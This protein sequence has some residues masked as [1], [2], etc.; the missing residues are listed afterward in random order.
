MTK[1]LIYLPLEKYKSR[2]TEYVS[3]ANGTFAACVQEYG[4]V[5]LDIIAPDDKVREITSGVVLDT[6]Q[7]VKWGFSQTEE[8]IRRIHSGEITSNSVIYIE[9]FWHPGMEM[10]PYAC[11]LQGIKPKVYALLHAQSVDPYDFTHPMASWMRGF[12]QGWANWLTGIFVSTK[13]LKSLVTS[14]APPYG[15]ITKIADK[16]HVVGLPYHRATVQNMFPPVTI[17]SSKPRVVFTSRFDAEKQPGKFLQLASVYRARH[18]EVEFM[19][20]SGRSLPGN[21]A[22]QAFDAGVVVSHNVS[23][24]CYFDLLST[25]NVMFN[26]ALQDFISWALIDALAYG[27]TPLLPDYLTFPDVVGNNPDLLYKNGDMHDALK[28]LDAL[29]NAPEKIDYWELY[30]KK[31]ER[32][33]ARMLDVMMAAPSMEEELAN[34]RRPNVV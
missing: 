14:V 30:G 12:E 23:K 10:I 34:C 33:A 29:L 16:V 13:E 1:K 3:G 8:L 11:H 17:R 32:V 22:K 18:P 2:Y 31:Y 5:E 15:A 24:A 4:R 25:S 7:R 19:I 9:D 26:C 28:K 21:W 20:I 6:Q 27:V